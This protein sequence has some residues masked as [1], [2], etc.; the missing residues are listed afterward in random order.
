MI[1]GGPWSGEA[2][3]TGIVLASGD[4]IATEVVTL[5]IIRAFGR[6]EMVTSKGVWDQEQIRCA[7]ALGVGARGPD[8]VELVAEDLMGGAPDFSR[9]LTAI[10]QNVGLR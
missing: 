3:P 8:E 7:I 1:R 4:P 10:R 5:G 9:L 6:W 2:V